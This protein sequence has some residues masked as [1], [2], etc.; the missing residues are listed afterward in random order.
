MRFQKGNAVPVG[1]LSASQAR[2][3]R[4]CPL[5]PHLEGADEAGFLYVAADRLVNRGQ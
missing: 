1:V 4:Q 3:E 2:V 5:H